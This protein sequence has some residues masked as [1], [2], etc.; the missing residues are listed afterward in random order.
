MPN[1]NRVGCAGPRERRAAP[2]SRPERS[3]R[4]NEKTAENPRSW[5]LISGHPAPQGRCFVGFSLFFQS[6]EAHRSRLIFGTFHQGKVQRK[7]VFLPR[8]SQLPQHKTHIWHAAQ[9]AR[10]HQL[11]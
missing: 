11:C 1:L 4:M 9:Y 3:R 2:G 7:I 5:P 8:E 6:G 10:I